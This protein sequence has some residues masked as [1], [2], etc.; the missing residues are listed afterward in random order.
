MKKKT[1]LRNISPP[2]LKIKV[3]KSFLTDF[4]SVEKF[5]LKEFF[6]EKFVNFGISL[7]VSVQSVTLC[8][9]C[10]LLILRMKGSIFKRPS[11]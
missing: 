7:F 8:S 6:L 4:E 11:L 2:P 10:Y 5:L 1:T 9:L 3:Q